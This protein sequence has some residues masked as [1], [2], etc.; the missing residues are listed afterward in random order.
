MPAATAASIGFI[1]QSESIGALREHVSRLLTR[2]RGARRLPPI[3]LE[4]ETGTGKGLLARWI[5]GNSSRAAAPFVDINC[6]AIP[7]TLLEAEL[8]GFERGA[9]TDARQS[10]PGL[11]QAA[12][13]GVLFLD[14]IGLLP[15][16]MQGKLLKAIE[17][18]VVRRLGR[19]QP[20]PVDVW[21]IAATS[22]DLRM[23]A[24]ARR[25]RED[26]YHRLAA[27]TFRLPPLRERGEDVLLL[28]EHFLA[29]ACA[30]YQ[31]PVKTLDGE[32]RQ[33]LSRYAW[34]GNVRE[35]ANVMERVAL[36]TDEPRVTP[37]ALDLPDGPAMPQSADEPSAA[38]PLRDAVEDVERRRIGQVLA[39][40][41]GNI[42]RAAARLG[43]P[44]STLRYRLEKLGVQEAVP[45]VAPDAGMPPAEGPEA[46]EPAASLARPVDWQR[47][48]LAL[49]RIALIPGAD[50][51]SVS[52]EQRLL[53]EV[54]AKVRG[55]GGRLDEQ[56]ETGFVAVFGFEPVEDACAR[57]AH[58]ALA[59]QNA[60]RRERGT[61]PS[62]PSVTCALHA[63]D[64]LAGHADSHP[65]LDMHDR[66][67]ARTVLEALALEA[68]EGA[69]VVSEAAAP[70]LERRFDLD[71]VSAASASP[72]PRYRI[73]GREAT[74]YGLAGRPLTP[75][76]GRASEMALLDDVRA[77]VHAGHGQVVALV[78][79]PGVGK[80]RITYELARA[81]TERGWQALEGHATSYGAAI[82]YLPLAD[83]LRR[84]FRLDDADGPRAIH[85][86]ILGRLSAPPDHGLGAVVAPLL[87]VLG[88]QVDD[89]EWQRLD[90]PE[91]RERILD[92]IKR[93]L[94]RES[95]R[96]PLILLFEDL[97]WVDAGTQACLDR[98]VEAVPTTRILLLV[99]YRPEYRH[100]WGNKTYYRQLPIDPLPPPTSGVLLDALLGGDASL[101][102]VKRLVIE[103]TE[104][105][106]F[107]IEESVRSLV[108]TG[109]LAGEHGAYQVAQ[110]V[111]ELN[112]PATVDS[113][114]SARIDRLAVD[115]KHLL[116]VASVIGKDVV[117]SL[118]LAIAD[119][120]QAEVRAR[121]SRLQA[122]E[123]VYEV[124]AFPELEY[125]F[126]H[127]LTHEVAYQG[128]LHDRRRALHA[129]VVAAIERLSAERIAEQSERLA[130]HATR[131]E[132]WEKAVGYLRQ[133]GLRAMA[134]AANHDAVAHLEEA[135]RALRRLPEV[136]ARTE[137]AID[138]HVDLRNALIPLGEWARMRDHLYAADVL[139]RTLGDEHR[140]AWIASFMVTQH[141]NTGDYDEAVRFGQEAIAIARTLGDR[142][143]EVRVTTTLG[144]T[145]AA[146]GEFG[147]AV[148]V[149]EQNV[150]REG[151]VRY[152]RIG[153]AILALAMS[154][155]H[156]AQ[157]L[158]QT[159]RFQDSI[160]HAEAAVHVAE[161][162]GHAFTLHFALFDLGLAHLRRG[163][164]PH[165]IRALERCLDLS[166]T[167]RM[168][169]GI[170]S[171]AAVL[172]VAYALAGRAGEALPL[173]ADAVE[174]F[175][176][177]PFHGRPARILLSAGTICLAAGQID[178]AAGHAR[179]A[180][181]LSRRLGARASEAEALH[182]A[183]DV[184][185][186]RGDADAEGHYREALALAGR[187]GMRPLAAHCHLGLGKLY[188]RAGKRQ[189]AQEHLTAATTMY[190]E[191]DMRFW[192]ERAEARITETA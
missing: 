82:P 33:A 11:F 148:A 54:L 91:R 139:A 146:R 169:L 38:G 124:R 122:A 125:T 131:G 66:H 84:Y 164:L 174:E 93:V 42:S 177:R 100:G 59:I 12:H 56:G 117:L 110:M 137:R 176:A 58:A 134:R 156:L 88:G 147:D 2:E 50:R 22:D 152:E 191:M 163:D 108:E 167:R 5:H 78:G 189:Q 79:D 171:T 43:V 74:G 96:Q 64:V 81:A 32:A 123:F 170:R 55:F 76:V 13:G 75:F 149:L 6:A 145:H 21:I 47:R 73:L 65:V 155:V 68:E 46:R 69:I 133:A 111:S 186:T 9:F 39:E 37:A 94:V 34:P 129:G 104:G 119:A 135:L 106:P 190:R 132:L 114:L 185:A 184:A 168:A 109:V 90:P 28:A 30:D 179:D 136:R 102:P 120:P 113:L 49:L 127:A 86:K 92:G 26:L 77:R 101:A 140:L 36:L 181:A 180:L 173:V 63:S 103:R 45:P 160:G 192:G 154:R 141:L 166:R 99:N 71:R 107:F 29:R 142:S 126:K 183:G 158:A 60:I 52:R 7:E 175:R 128:L 162:A 15:D 172:G 57:A 10:K 83:L 182:L 138:I 165:A 157:V 18:R 19:V 150:A 48:H 118:L 23:S 40:T 44:R 14:E 24:R 105:N 16:G 112:A 4:G 17:E 51:P 1:G 130:H 87:A 89:G 72:A 8:F 188:R 151:D 27:L 67:R 121:L 31:L 153:G 187:L 41:G 62:T 143:I 144:E 98:L 161:A 115:D 116:Q 20:E 61:D 97:H 178:E 70:L 85:E 95:E 53:D 35:L 80:S 159:G 25:F 3:L